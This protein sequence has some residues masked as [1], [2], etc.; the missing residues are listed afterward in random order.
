MEAGAG[1]MIRQLIAAIDDAYE[2]KAKRADEKGGPNPREVVNT[3]R[4]ILGS[5]AT[6]PPNPGGAFYGFVASRM[7]FGNYSLEDVERAA[8]HVK[9]HWKLPTSVEWIIRKMDEILQEAES[10]GAQSE[11]SEEVELNLGR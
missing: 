11:D 10:R 4:G 9:L 1:P 5:K 2:K 7:K 3:I 6:I 8:L